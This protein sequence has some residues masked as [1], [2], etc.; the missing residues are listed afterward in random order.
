MTDIL[1]PFFRWIIELISL[2]IYKKKDGNQEFEEKYKENEDDKMIYVIIFKILGFLI[3]IF[4]SLVF[5]EIIVLKFYNFDKN[6]KKNIQ[7]RG[8]DELINKDNLDLS[9]FSKDEN[10]NNI[11]CSVESEMSEI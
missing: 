11:N 6:I 4:T 7:N 5:N 10:F 3:I 2:S 1:S 9:N 8:D